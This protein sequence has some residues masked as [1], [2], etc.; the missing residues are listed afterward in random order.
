[1]GALK[2]GCHN[3][4]FDLEIDAG[5]LQ[6]LL[7]IRMR[8]QQCLMLLELCADLSDDAIASCQFDQGF[9][10]SSCRCSTPQSSPPLPYACLSTPA[11]VHA[12]FCASIRP[13]S[14]L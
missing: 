14:L 12:H 2:K 7:Q 6:E 10:L 8:L 4:G 1:L 13:G 11:S 5:I 3:A 9:R